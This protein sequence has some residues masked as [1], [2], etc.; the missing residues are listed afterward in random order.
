VLLK[1]PLLEKQR[2]EI[3][4][5]LFEAGVSITLGEVK[6]L[7]E[8]KAAPIIAKFIIVTGLLG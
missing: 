4:N 7:K 6:I 2:Y 5:E 8:L 3:I 1:C